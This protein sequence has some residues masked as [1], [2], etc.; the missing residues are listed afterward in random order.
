MTEH[1]DKNGDTGFEAHRGIQTATRYGDPG[2]AGFISRSFAKS[3]GFSDDTL[4]RPVVGIVQ[5]WSEI[6]NCHQNFRELAAAVKRGVY[7]AGGLPLEFPTISLGEVFLNPTSMMFRNLM[8]IDTEE[9]IRAQPIDGVVLLGSCDKTIPAQLMGAASADLPAMMVTGGPTLSGR[10]NGRDLGAC[11]D[12]RGFWTEHRAG[13]IDA[14]TLR[15][16]E[17]SLCRSAGHCT[18]M[19]TASTMAGMVE[20]LGMTIPGMAAIPAPDSR[21]MRIAETAGRQAVELIKLGIRP[22]QV[23]T[24]RAFENAIRVML[25]LGGSTNAVVHIIAVAGRLGIELPLELFDELSRSTPLLANIRPAGKWQMEQLFEAGGVPAVIRE[26]LPLL[27]GDCLTITGRTLAEEY[28]SARNTNTD[29]VAPLDRPLSHEGGMAIL[30]GNLAPG[31]ALIKHSAATPA[32]LQHRGQ[33]IV[34]KDLDELTRTIDDPNLDVTPDSILVMQ[35]GGPVGAPGFPE[36]GNLP[37]PRKLLEQGIRD[38]VRISDARMSGTA[39]GT[40]VLHVTPESAVGGPL[41]LVRTGD[42]IE[43]DVENRRLTLDVDEQELARRRAEWQAPA[44]TQT[45]G[46]AKLYVDHVLQADRGADLD[47]LVG[48]PMPAETLQPA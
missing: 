42:W 24:R 20:A 43:L 30:R 35:S 28:E 25:A 11:T 47:F 2:L 4:R 44:R 3:F 12:C 46:W 48:E 9:M 16:I 19:G 14:D 26:L 8:A 27:H 32:L 41:A 33:A 5:T 6:N 17:D 39:Y 37:I 40:V 15:D 31:G 38:I 36:S 18:V 34:F 23:M 10:W 45:R 22:S 7:Q 29:I 13:K 1:T 21:R